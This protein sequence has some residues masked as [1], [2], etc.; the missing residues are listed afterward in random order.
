[1]ARFVLVRHGDDPDDDRVVGYF[2]AKGIEPDI[3]RP[4]K[5]ERLGDVD[6][7]VAGS[8]IYGGPFNVFDEDL[9]P[10]LHDEARWIR[11][12]MAAHVPLLGICQGAQ[13]IA[14]VLGAEVGPMDG[15]PTEFGYYEIT[16]MEAGRASFPDRFVVAQSHFHAFQIPPGAELLAGS[17][18]FPQQAFKY[19]ARTFGLQF[20]AEVTPPGF[21]RWQDAP[22]ARYGKP[23]AQTRQ[24][25]DQL[26]AAH[27][28]AQHQWFMGFLERLFGEAV[29][30]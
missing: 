15:E 26:M 22:W 18:L 19:G 8:V 10:F 28:A 23:G 9:H 5:G 6:R 21:R 14:R 4:F 17:A 1:M 27:D 24:E 7:T 29:R 20:H 13:Q 12:C 2:R 11:Q 25:Q 16:P 30:G 3:V